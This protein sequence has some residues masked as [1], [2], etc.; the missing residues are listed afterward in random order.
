MRTSSDSEAE[1]IQDAIDDDD[2]DVRYSLRS[3]R[4]PKTQVTV[5]S[6]SADLG[7]VIN[8]GARPATD[9]AGRPSDAVNSTAIH[10][11]PSLARSAGD[12]AHEDRVNDVEDGRPG[13]RMSS[14]PGYSTSPFEIIPSRGWMSAGPRQAPA[15]GATTSA[16]TDAGMRDKIRISVP[17]QFDRGDIPYVPP[18]T[19]QVEPSALTSTS[20]TRMTTRVQERIR[21]TDDQLLTWTEYHQQHAQ[22]M[23]DGRRAIEQIAR[24]N[25]VDSSDD[26]VVKLHPRPSLDEGQTSYAG[27]LGPESRSFG[28]ER[29][30]GAQDAGMAADRRQPPPPRRNLDIAWLHYQSSS[31]SSF[32]ISSSL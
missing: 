3:R 6:T 19:Q 5:I 20:A 18:R 28:I 32:S 30:V 25:A 12:P 23:V 29:P 27:R 4:V 2:D 24:G 17:F 9:V 13:R 11:Q 1:A 8:E 22:R 26:V 14:G 21:P 10:M 15:S 7:G 31:L 16:Y